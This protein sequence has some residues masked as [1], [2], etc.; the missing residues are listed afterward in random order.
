MGAH[1]YGRFEY[2]LDAEASLCP[3]PDRQLVSR[4]GYDNTTDQLLVNEGLGG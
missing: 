2:L 3:T 1:T 4:E